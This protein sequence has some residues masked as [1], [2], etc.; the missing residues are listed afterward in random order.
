M[1][2]PSKDFAHHDPSTFFP[3]IPSDAAAGRESRRIGS[4]ARNKALQGVFKTNTKPNAALRKQLADQL[5]MTPRGVQCW[6]QNMRAKAKYVASKEAA[7]DAAAC[8][9]RIKT[10]RT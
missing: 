5:E 10:Y 2:T 8:G 1:L 7:A 3:Y 9:K 6:F 4:V